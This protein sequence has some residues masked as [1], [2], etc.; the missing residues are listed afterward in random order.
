LALWL[1][2]SDQ[3]EHRMIRAPSQPNAGATELTLTV[4]FGDAADDALLRVL[5]TLHRRRCRVTAAEFAAGRRTSGRLALRIQAPAAHADRIGHWL[6]SLVDVRHVSTA[7]APAS[8]SFT[9]TR[10]R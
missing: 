4:E 7:A 3:K 2:R 6:N 5:T 1:G 9:E 8:R 10:G